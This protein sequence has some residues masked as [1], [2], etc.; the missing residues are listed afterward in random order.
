M[1]QMQV[2]CQMLMLYLLPVLRKKGQPNRLTHRD[3]LTCE[4][5]NSTHREPDYN[6]IIVT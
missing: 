2:K 3:R 5:I 1:Y 6:N 4:A